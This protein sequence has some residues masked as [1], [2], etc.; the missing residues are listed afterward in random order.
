[1][2]KHNRMLPAIGAATLLA[3]LIGAPAHAAGSGNSPGSGSGGTTFSAAKNAGGKANAMMCK[4]MTVDGGFETPKL[5]S[6]DDYK[7][8]DESDVPGWRTDD[9]AGKIEIWGGRMGV[10]PRFG[11]QFAEINA[12]GSNNSIYEDIKTKSNTKIYWSFWIR[13]RDTSDGKDVDATSIHFGK[14]PKNDTSVLGI[15]SQFAYANSSDDAHWKRLYGWYK[16]G[17]NQASTR[18]TLTADSTA[19]TDAGYGNLVD[20]LTITES[21]NC[22]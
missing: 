16:T 20:G 18:V 21:A 4:E 9:P 10:T 15:G 6:G 3:T 13:A 22:M 11:K 19:A 12:T 8:Y 17:P 1:M 7:L 14:T 5:G 2:F